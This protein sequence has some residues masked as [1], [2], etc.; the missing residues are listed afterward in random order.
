MGEAAALEKEGVERELQE[1]LADAPEHCGEGFRLV[2]REWPTDIGPV[3]LMCR[4]PDDGWVAVEIKRV[5][6]ID[7]V[8]QLTRYLERIGGR[9]GLRRPAAACWPPRRSSPR[10]ACS[11]SRAASPAWRWTRRCC[12]A[13]AC[14]T[15]RCS[16]LGWTSSAA[17]AGR[18]L[19]GGPA[20]GRPAG[21]RAALRAADDAA[22]GGADHRDHRDRACR[23]WPTGSSAGDRCHAP[24]GALIGSCSAWA[25]RRGRVR[26]DHPAVHRPDERVRGRRAGIVDD[27]RDQIHD[28]T[29][30]K[31]GEIADRVQDFAERLHGRPGQADRPDHLDRPQR[32]GRAWRRCS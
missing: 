13:S 6:T 5:G 15:S 11:P 14:P 1:L 25:V 32:G 3:D 2:R 28:L 26:P 30:A 16:P 17:P 9:S 8:E 29:G 19:P 20:G 27:L 21:A 4:D 24:I 23:R 18:R 31:P 22:A 10:R 12:A 7:A